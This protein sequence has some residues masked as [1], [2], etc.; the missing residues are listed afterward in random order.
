MLNDASIHG[1]CGM[2]MDILTASIHER[3]PKP[4]MNISWEIVAIAFELSQ[5]G[6]RH[7]AALILWQNNRLPQNFLVTDNT[8]ISIRQCVIR[9][10]KRYMNYI[11]SLQQRGSTVGENLAK[12]EKK[13][14]V[15]ARIG[16]G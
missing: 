2:R 15:A 12:S 10:A 8:P 16:K 3:R 1:Y 14:D 6:N 7:I 9:V 4:L 11:V 13:I 5:Y